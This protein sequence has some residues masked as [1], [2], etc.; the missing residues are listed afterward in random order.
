MLLKF[1]LLYKFLSLFQLGFD[2]AHSLSFQ[3]K[4]SSFLVLGSFLWLVMVCCFRLIM[5]NCLCDAS[6]YNYLFDFLFHSSC[7]LFAIIVVSIEVDNNSNN[8]VLNSL[9]SGIY[10]CHLVPRV[11]PLVSPVFCPSSY[12]GSLV[13]VSE[14]VSCISSFTFPSSSFPSFYSY[15]VFGGGDPFTTS[16]PYKVPLFVSDSKMYVYITN[17]V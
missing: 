5:S 17:I 6:K 9:S 15:M 8:I 10:H 4:E 13:N 2:M 7:I 1:L 14:G 11:S 12:V 3:Y 16:L